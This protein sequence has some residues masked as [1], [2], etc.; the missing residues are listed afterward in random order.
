MPNKVKVVMP[1]L[2]KDS[3]TPFAEAYKALRT[4]LDYYAASEDVH[5]VLFASPEADSDKRTFIRNLAV[6]LAATGH[7]VMLADFD[8]RRGELTESLKITAGHTGVSDVLT[9][10][11]EATEAMV[12]GQLDGVDVLPSGV[13]CADPAALFSNDKTVDLL[14]KLRE[15]YDFVLLNAP[16]VDEYTDA[17]VLSRIVDATVLLIAAGTTHMPAAQKC[18]AKLE[19]VNAK[20]LGAVL[21]NYDP[22]SL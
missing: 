2:G 22:K 9:G 12:H 7:S 3:Q 20:I 8:L 21:T 11:A 13:V 4:N 1:P 5:T 15:Q 18:K 10:K 19:T 16:C 6:T 14:S 17:V